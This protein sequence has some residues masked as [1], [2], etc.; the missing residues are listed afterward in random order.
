LVFSFGE[1]R[2]YQHLEVPHDPQ[3]YPSPKGG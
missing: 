1:V 3:S 2:D